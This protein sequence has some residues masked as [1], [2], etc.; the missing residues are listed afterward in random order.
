MPPLSA[1]DIVIADWRGDPLPKE[2]NKLRPAVVIQDETLFAPDF[3]NVL[4]VPLSDDETLAIPG[5][6]EPIAPTAE[7]GCTKLCFAISPFAASTSVARLRTTSSR[8]T[9]AQ[10]AHIRRQVAEAI[11]LG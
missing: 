11:G 10:L 2:P 5:L 9:A 1:G 3:P 4:L 6:T 8:I 7:N